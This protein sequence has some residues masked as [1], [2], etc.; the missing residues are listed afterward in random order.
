MD[1]AVR[2][3]IFEGPIDLLLHL[4]RKNEVDIHD[5]PVALITRQYLEYLGL[6]RELNIAVAGEFLVMAS[7]LTHIKS[8]MLL[9]ALRDQPDDEDPDDPRHDLVQQLRQHMSIKL[10]AETLQGR[11]W[12]D[13]DVFQRAAASQEL[14]AAAKARPQEL[15]AAGV[16]EL[17]EAFRQLIA[18]RGRQL[19]LDLPL[20]RVSLEDRMS[21]L[22][23]MLRR[24]QSLTFEEC[25]A[26]DLD[27]SHMVVTFLAIL[28]L[29]RMGLL[30]VYQS[31]A[32]QPDEQP[33][34]WSALRVFARDIDEEAEE[35]AP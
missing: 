28:E 12:L 4:I 1:V 5:I 24:R 8:R 29:T 26:G 33:A 9:P 13:R 23:S 21:D 15:V 2:L 17:I 10:A 11:N 7:T 22:L 19:V 32:P 27:K 30:R 16:F 18:A 3:E 20:A 35:A 25:F 14:D 34:A 31:R 6:M